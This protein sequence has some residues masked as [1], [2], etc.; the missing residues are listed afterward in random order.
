MSVDTTQK[1][2][3]SNE[4]LQLLKNTFAERDEVLYALRKHMLQIELDEQEQKLVDE[5]NEDT[6]DVLKTGFL[7][8]IEGEMPLQQEVDL[9]MLAKIDDK[10]VEEAHP[11]IMARQLMKSYLEAMLGGNEEV[12]SFKGLGIIT[13]DKEQNYINIIAKQ[14]IFTHIESQLQMIK[15]ISGKKEETP[16]ETMERLQKNSSK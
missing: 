7:P 9:W 2:R 10:T 1:S 4:D 11:H 16:E 8:T 12:I 14:L 5:I 3:Y 6:Q 13:N 15:M